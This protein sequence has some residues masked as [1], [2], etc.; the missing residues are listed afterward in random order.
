MLFNVRQ[1]VSNMSS[2][3]EETD[4]RR[5]AEELQDEMEEMKT[6]YENRVKTLEEVILAVE[7]ELKNEKTKNVT[8]SRVDQT[9]ISEE[10]EAEEETTSIKSRGHRSDPPPSDESSSPSSNSSSSSEDSVSSDRRRNRLTMT[11]KD[12]RRGQD[13]REDKGETYILNEEEVTALT[14]TDL[15][16]YSKTN[17]LRYG[18]ETYYKILKEAKKIKRNIAIDDEENAEITK[19]EVFIK[20]LLRTEEYLLK[21]VKKRRINIEAAA[22]DLQSDL[23]VPIFNNEDVTKTIYQFE[24]EWYSYCQLRGILFEESGPII[25]RSITGQAKSLVKLNISS[26]D[27]DASKTFQ[28]LKK[29][30]GRSEDIIERC[31]KKHQDLGQIG[32]LGGENTPSSILFSAS[33]HLNIIKRVIEPITDGYPD[34]LDNTLYTDSVGKI[35]PCGL[36]QEYFQQENKRSETGKLRFLIQILEEISEA[37]HSANRGNPE[38]ESKMEE[39]ETFEEEEHEEHDWEE[40]DDEEAEENDWE[41]EDD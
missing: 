8:A 41:E 38:E 23:T 34:I 9:P 19:M 3:D 30:Y 2:E 20:D 32:Q 37:A 18:T 33:E 4:W 39:K 28:L 25:L 22:P 27:P 1:P 21:E 35:L 26:T 31:I 40:Q 36:Q 7:E 16:I 15:K 13:L 10:S 14:N 24:K 29:H 17:S 6:H 5:K 11:T 12:V